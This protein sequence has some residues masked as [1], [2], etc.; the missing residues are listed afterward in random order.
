MI[1]RFIAW[2]LRGAAAFGRWEIRWARAVLFWLLIPE[3][4]AASAGRFA[5]DWLPRGA[6]LAATV[7]LWIPARVWATAWAAAR[8]IVQIV[9]SSAQYVRRSASERTVIGVLGLLALCT[10]VGLIAAPVGLILWGT[11]L[12]AV[13]ALPELLPR[14]RRRA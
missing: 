14:L 9:R 12:L 5:G 10:G 13:A 11:V 3:P 8:R 1:A 4:W 7:V 2:L 6:R